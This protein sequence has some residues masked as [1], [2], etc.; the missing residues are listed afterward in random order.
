[1]LA[2][3]ARL[4]RQFLTDKKIRRLLA[5][6]TAQWWR[7]KGMRQRLLPIGL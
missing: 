4:E 5:Q 3:V 2:A 6:H 1:V 7:G